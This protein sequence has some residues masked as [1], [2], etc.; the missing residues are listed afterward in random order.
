MTACGETSVDESPAAALCGAEA[1]PV[2]DALVEKG[3]GVGALAVGPVVANGGLTG[4][5]VPAE[6]PAGMAL[7]AKA[8]DAESW[9]LPEAVSVPAGPPCPSG[10]PPQVV[11]HE[12]VDEEF[13]AERSCC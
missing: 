8:T 3:V 5:F 13:A 7:P 12:P 11:V 4:A 2:D 9:V 10:L 1:V 6:G